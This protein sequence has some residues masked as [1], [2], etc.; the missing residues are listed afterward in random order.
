[1][2]IV[3]HSGRETHLNSSVAELPHISK[4]GGARPLAS[5]ARFS[6]FPGSDEIRTVESCGLLRQ[7]ILMDLRDADRF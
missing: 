1:M 5:A 6:T 4:W 3:F 7:F 2:F